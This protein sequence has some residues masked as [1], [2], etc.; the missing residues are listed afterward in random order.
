MLLRCLFNYRTWPQ[1][2]TSK[3]ENLVSESEAMSKFNGFEVNFGYVIRRKKKLLKNPQALKSKRD[4]LDRDLSSKPVLGGEQLALLF[5]F[6]VPLSDGLNV[7]NVGD[8]CSPKSR[9]CI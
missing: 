5:C 6:F 2:F 8:G 1:R 4:L 7:C 3:S 9:F